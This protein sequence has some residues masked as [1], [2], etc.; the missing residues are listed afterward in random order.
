MPVSPE[1]NDPQTDRQM[2]EQDRLV[3]VTELILQN[4]KVQVLPVSSRR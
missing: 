4:R 3:H 1:E 2:K